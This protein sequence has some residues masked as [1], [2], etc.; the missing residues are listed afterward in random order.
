MKLMLLENDVK[1]ARD[2][3]ESMFSQL[4]D[5][6]YSWYLLAVSKN[7]YPDGPQLSEKAREIANQLGVEDSNG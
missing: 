5:T 7:I 4:N 3:R 2:F 1:L 6:L